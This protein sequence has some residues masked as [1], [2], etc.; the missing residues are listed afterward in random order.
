MSHGT[1]RLETTAG[2][3]MLVDALVGAGVST[4]VVA[5]GSRSTPL[6]AALAT[7]P[8]VRTHVVH[9]ERSGA[10]VALGVGR[11]GQLAALLTTSGTA[12]ANALPAVVE[13]DVD[14]V[15]LV[16]LSADRPV[17]AIDTDANQ[18]IDQRFFF[19]GRVRAFVDVPPPEDQPDPQC[20]ADAVVD[21]V[22]KVHHAP[23][24]P[25]H[26]NARYRKPLEPTTTL[27]VGTPR[28]RSP[29]PGPTV[30]DANAEAFVAAVASCRDGAGIM[31]AGAARD[32]EETR[33]MAALAEALRWPVIA[34]ATSGLRGPQATTAPVLRAASILAQVETHWPELDVV[35]RLGG[36]FVD[37]KLALLARHARLIVRVDDDERR[38]LEHAGPTTSVRAAPAALAPKLV[39]APGRGTA[40]L[41]PWQALFQ[42]SSDA[43]Q[44]LDDGDD[45][46]GDD[47]DGDHDGIVDEP[48]VARLCASA[49][50]AHEGQLFVG[51]S[52][53]IRAV[54]RFCPV[55][56]RV[57]ANRG[58][59]GI[60]GLLSTAAGLALGSG[61]TW[62]LVG[63][64][65]FLHDAGS[66]SA[67]SA[68]GREG[69]AL[70]I[71]V[72][73][74]GGGRIFDHLP[75]AAHHALLTPF[76]T[77]PHDVDLVA[78]AH[79]YRVPAWRIATAGDLTKR[80]HAPLRGVEVL[81]VVVDGD[82]SVARHRHRYAS[83]DTAKKGRS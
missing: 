36:G 62:A 35:V 49:A 38:R 14:H 22:A 42:R 46:D 12:V 73:D 66:L 65:S 76:F 69:L 6:V 34:C 48:L 60:D 52:I 82:A 59:S 20:Y 78:L 53:P 79:A 17:E 24:G 37:E 77:T 45:N 47:N 10:F 39:V 41:S 27:A 3:R 56:R 21:A 63:D 58:A 83:I 61:P 8:R 54:D 70:R 2:A 7:D 1:A 18:T 30:D 16:V 19:G 55:V 9:D 74:N 67:F 57:V 31:L 11:T 32:D 64:V 25:V 68:W 5:P 51:N 71:V 75:I 43:E 4:F 72:I 81:V 80:L 33:G 29:R 50:L 40:S 28:R 15:P 13:A 23:R 26:I 44:A